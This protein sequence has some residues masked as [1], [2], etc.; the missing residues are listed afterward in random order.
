M[1]PLSVG[2]VTPSSS[3]P[4]MQLL[5]LGIRTRAFASSWVLNSEIKAS[6]SLLSTSLAESVGQLQDQAKSSP[7]SSRV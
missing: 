5:K 1:Q 7:N 2:N 4:D 6:I 3:A